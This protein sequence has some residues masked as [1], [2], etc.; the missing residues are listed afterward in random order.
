LDRYSSTGTYYAGIRHRG[1]LIRKS[2]ETPDCPLAK[3]RMADFRR[4]LEKVDP[5]AGRVTI[6]EL[7]DRYRETQRHL[8]EKTQKKKNTIT[9]RIKAEWP[10]GSDTYVRDVRESQIGVWLGLQK[11]RMGKAGFNDYV[12]HIR[13][14]FR[15]AVG[16]KIIADSP[17]ASLKQMKRDKPIRET[18][19][20]EQFQAVVESIRAQHLHA[21]C[22]D[23]A[24]F[25]EFLGLAGLGNAEAASLTWG[26]VDFAKGKIRVYDADGMPDAWE[27]LWASPTNGFDQNREWA[28]RFCEDR[29][30][31]NS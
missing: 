16:D 7:A 10:G 30:F 29:R 20:W 28:S 21:E 25:V 6:A 9:G 14:V 3:R 18:P 23:S 31:S 2:L 26:D 15:L 4:S 11:Q 13:A 5:K 19:T 8:A 12:E 1:K 17:A 24:D 27:S 22:A